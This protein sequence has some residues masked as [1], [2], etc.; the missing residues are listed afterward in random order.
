MEMLNFIFISS[1]AL[2]TSTK[3]FIQIHPLFPSYFSTQSANLLLRP[4]R[5][6]YCTIV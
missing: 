2:G 3:N 6:T 5:V 4:L 1:P